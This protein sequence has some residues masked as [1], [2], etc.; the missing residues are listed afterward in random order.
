ML[1]RSILVEGFE[2]P[3]DRAFERA[4]VLLVMFEA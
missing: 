1:R 4:S 2:P 3:G